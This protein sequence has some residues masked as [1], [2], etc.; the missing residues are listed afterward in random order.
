MG[1]ISSRVPPAGNLTWD[2]TE[3]EEEGDE[4]EEDTTEESESLSISN[5][6]ARRLNRGNQAL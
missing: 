2:T 3:E 6:P 1:V 5:I 4:E